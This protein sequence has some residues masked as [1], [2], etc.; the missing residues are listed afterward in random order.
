[1]GTDGDEGRSVVGD[2][3]KLSKVDRETGHEELVHA[4]SSH[5]AALTKASGTVSDHRRL[6]AFVY[7][8]LRDNMPCGVMA[9]I[10]QM[11]TTLTGERR[12]TLFGHLDAAAMWAYAER[13]TDSTDEGLRVT[14]LEWVALV[15]RFSEHPDRLPALFDLLPG[16]DDTETIFTNG[17][18]ATYAQ[19][20]VDELCKPPYA[21]ARA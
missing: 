2:P 18:V 21:N 5:V 17:W 20:I 14:V 16:A 19:Y 3:T 11:R 4:M 15:F 10:M 13:L 1:M 9:E 7:L 12:I 8:L 6:V